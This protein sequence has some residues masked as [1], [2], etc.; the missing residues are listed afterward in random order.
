MFMGYQV[1]LSGRWDSLNEPGSRVTSSYTMG[2]GDG[3][4][5]TVLYEYLCLVQFLQETI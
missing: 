4:I 3:C 2:G 5:R 1:H